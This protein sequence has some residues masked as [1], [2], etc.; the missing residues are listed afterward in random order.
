MM[1]II[2]LQL[3]QPNLSEWNSLINSNANFIVANSVLDLCRQV[4]VREREWER[5]RSSVYNDGVV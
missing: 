5:E 3:D 2:V 4:E 1:T